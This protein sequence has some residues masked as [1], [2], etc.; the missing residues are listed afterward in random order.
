MAVIG[1]ANLPTFEQDVRVGSSIA[2]SLGGEV[3]R[4]GLLLL[5]SYGQNQS[6]N[7]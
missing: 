7:R 5:K 1:D 2:P 6:P 4:P 3:C